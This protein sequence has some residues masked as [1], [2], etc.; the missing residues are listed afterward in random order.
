[1]KITWDREDGYPEHA[2]GYIQWSVRPYRLGDGFDGTIDEYVHYLAKLFL[3]S[4]GLNYFEIY[5]QAYADHDGDTTNMRDLPRTYGNDVADQ[6]DIPPVNKE[7]F[8]KLLDELTDINNHSF[9][10]AT[11]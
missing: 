9:V 5:D 3:E 1:M 7:N 11:T 2:W 8:G 10:V 6:I 4:I